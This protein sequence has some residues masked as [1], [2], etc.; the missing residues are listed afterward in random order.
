MFNYE[1]EFFDFKATARGLS[2]VRLC[3]CKT[4]KGFSRQESK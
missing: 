2:T 4:V 1:T 3:R